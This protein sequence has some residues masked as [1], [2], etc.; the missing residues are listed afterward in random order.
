MNIGAFKGFCKLAA[1][2]LTSIPSWI[3][4]TL[5]PAQLEIELW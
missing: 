5:Y 2:E 3:I 1:I 4:S